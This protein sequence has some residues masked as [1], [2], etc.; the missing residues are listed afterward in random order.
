MDLDFALILTVAVL[1]AGVIW[2]FDL[3][4]LKPRRQARADAAVAKLQDLEESLPEGKLDEVRQGEMRESLLVEYAHSFFPVL[5]VVWLLR[6]FL[7]EP[8]TIPSGSM[9]PTLQVGDY[10]LVNKF[11]YGLRLPVLGT[12]LL[13]LGEPHRGDVMVFKYPED[14]SVNFIKRVI[15]VP[16]DHVRVENGRVYVNDA[17]L[18]REK[19]DFPDA[20]SWE[21]YYREKTGEV[22]HLIRHEEGREATSPQGEWVVPAGSYFMMGDNRDNSRD[23]RYWG[24]VPERLIVGKASYIWMHKEPGLHLP[25]LNRDGKVH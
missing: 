25:V 14:T 19:A 11:I 1:V 21:L 15:G 4:F 10:I 17:E 18:P 16:G 3:L 8:F 13:P 12:T 6:S 20:E 24:F 7:F 5:F 23:S 2:G 9:L 22:S